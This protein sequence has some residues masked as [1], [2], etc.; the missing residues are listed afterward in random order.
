MET[1]YVSENLVPMCQTTHHHIP[2]DFDGN[3]CLQD[4]E[5]ITLN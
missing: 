3:E 5:W 4:A 2:E 1:T